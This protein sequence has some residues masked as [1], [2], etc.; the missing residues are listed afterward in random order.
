MISVPILCPSMALT[1]FCTMLEQASTQATF[2][3]NSLVLK[4][5]QVWREDRRAELESQGGR[6][7]VRLMKGHPRLGGI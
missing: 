7:G 3:A 5:E 1:L 6:R 2:T 4:V